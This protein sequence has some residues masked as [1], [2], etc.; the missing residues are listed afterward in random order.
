MEPAEGNSTEEIKKDS[1]DSSDSRNRAFTHSASS[2]YSDQEGVIVLKVIFDVQFKYLKIEIEDYIQIK[3][4]KMVT[5]AFDKNQT[6]RQA[7]A[8]IAQRGSV[9]KFDISELRYSLFQV[10]NSRTL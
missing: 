5:L 1:M 4:S 6:V 9:G 2:A 8:Q 10:S 3:S 7:L